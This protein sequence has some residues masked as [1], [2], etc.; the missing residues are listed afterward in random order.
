MRPYLVA[1]LLL[2]LSAYY[3]TGGIGFESLVTA[4]D[5][6][7]REAVCEVFSQIALV[8]AMV[9]LALRPATKG[10]VNGATP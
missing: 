7:L 5:I 8:G 9:V 6:T 10:P 4:D 2:G 1:L 3:Q